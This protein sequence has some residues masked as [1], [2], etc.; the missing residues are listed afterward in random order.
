MGRSLRVATRM[1]RRAER[2]VDGHS[3][4]P[5]EKGRSLDAPAKAGPPDALESNIRKMARFEEE[6]LL[7]RS[8][9]EK[10]SDRFTSAA[11]AGGFA[12]LHLVWFA[13]WILANLEIVP[14][15]R[16]FDP[17]PWSL[18]GFLVSLEAIFL[19]IAVL[20]SQ[21]R[22]SRHAE[23]RAQ[24]DLQINL[25]AEQESTRTLQLLERICYHLRIETQDGKGLDTDTDVQ[26]VKSELENKLPDTVH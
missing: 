14:G 22:M 4:M 2:A 7:K 10:L 16:A 6:A 25:L 9:A 21:N 18:L 5:A 8:T 26:Q 24:L 12:L 11:G 1:K 20:I 3:A 23:R 15:L 13:G 17:Y 19:S